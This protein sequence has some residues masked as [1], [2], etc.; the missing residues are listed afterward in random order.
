MKKT[1][2]SI[3]ILIAGINA[4]FGQLNTDRIQ[5]IGIN[6]LYFEDYIL[7]IQYFNQVIK[8][9]PY[10]SEPYLNRA[11]AKI[12]LDDFIGAEQDCSKSIEINPFV[13]RTYYARGYVR[14]RLGRYQD[15]IDDFNKAMEFSPS[16]AGLYLSRA[17]S[18]EK[19][20]EY[21]DAISD[22][23]AAKK[24]DPTNHDMDYN[25][26][27]IQLEVKDTTAAIQSFDKYIASNPLDPKGYSVRGVLKMQRNDDKGAYQDYTNA[28]KNKTDYV[29]DYIN[30][31]I[32]NVQKNN[33]NEALSDYNN[34]IQ[35]DPK[36][37]LAYY[38]RG[39]LRSNLGD[40]NNAIGDLAKVVNMDTTNYEARLQK[41]YLE[42][43]VG[44][45]NGA[46]A[47][48]KVILKRYPYFVPAYYG[49]ANAYKKSGNSK[50][51]DR[52]NYLGFNMENNRDYY[53]KKQALVAKNQIAKDALK[54]KDGENNINIF[55]ETK[56][57]VK[58]SSE[59]KDKYDS[60]LRGNVQDKFTEATIENN[61]ILSYYSGESE[62]RQTNTYYPYISQF[63]SEKKLPLPL[64]LTNQ[65]LILTPEL[66]NYH[67]EQINKISSEIEKTSENPY[68]Y[69]ARAL[70]FSL[71]KDYA[72]AIDDLSKAIM[73]KKDFALAIFS[74]ANIRLKLLDYQQNIKKMKNID[75]KNA[76]LA[77]NDVNT[78]LKLIIFDFTTTTEL[79][80][81]F[82]FSYYDLGNVFY[83]LGNFD[84]AIS[85]YTTAIKI[86]PDF[87]EAY[88][89]RGLTYLN[90]DNKEQ[91]SLDLSKS[92]ELGIY[93]AYNILKRLQE[94]EN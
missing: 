31:G 25:I 6:A 24:L 73:L 7:A 8:I 52:Y 86:D 43:Q 56:A 90:K 72:G 29:G 69:Y 76:D 11:I 55:G 63:N 71:V 80:P 3:F 2:L 94:K 44:D 23:E 20:K 18:K 54:T 34:A 83:Q 28:I 78:Q 27:I 85:N 1:I 45:L 59:E 12:K 61:F 49:I 68:L 62:I 67:F 14:N 81:D 87:A 26:G 22:I 33:F 10:L 53:K 84:D 46:I 13:P 50:E 5:D 35:K 48:Y 70:E 77:D 41:A 36:S 82:A 37:V 64:K 16:D 47:D 19:L 58:D 40:Y 93:Q 89:N 38:N 65:E 42:L 15:A 91:G 4:G 57:D 39:L 32:L 9:K 88:Y 17:E 51:A 92:G 75:I 79:L 74:R 21:K 60:K 30:R 66:I